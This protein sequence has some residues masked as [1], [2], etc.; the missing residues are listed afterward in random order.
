MSK[1]LSIYHSHLNNAAQILQ[2][3]DGSIPFSHFVKNYFSQN[4]K[5]GSKDRKQITSLCYVFFRL[6]KSF[7]DLTIKERI[8]VGVKNAEKQFDAQWQQLIEEYQPTSTA[9][10]NIFPWKDELSRTIDTAAFEAS[11]AIQPSLFLRIRPGFEY[12]VPKKLEK[13]GFEFSMS[14]NVIELPGATKIDNTLLVNTEVVVQDMS[15][16]RMAQFFDLVKENFPDDCKISIYD[17]C[18]ASGGKSILANDVLHNIALTVSDIRPSI[19]ANLHKRFKEA[20][21]TQYHSFVADIS[22]SF[23]FK[24]PQQ[25]DLVIADVPCTGSGTWARTPEQ[26]YFFDENKIDEYVNLQKKILQNILKTVRPKGFLFYITCSVFRRENEDQIE[27]I[28]KKGFRLVNHQI[29]KGY[30]KKADSMFGALLQN[31]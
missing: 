17:C 16:Q 22:N 15:S 7:P 21:I 25:F 24:T 23:S 28:L 6:G 20:G 1:N 5:F 31:S 3:Y 30:E 9:P 10:Q 19:I 13:A 26:L 2:L 18:A 12:T 29:I 27:K 14:E 8:L 4:K 11:F